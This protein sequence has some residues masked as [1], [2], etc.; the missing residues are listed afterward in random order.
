MSK[1]T[2]TRHR[3]TRAALELFVDQGIAA[4]TTRQITDRAKVAEGTLYRHFDSKEALAW[5]LFLDH[6]RELGRALRAAMHGPE[7]FA[8]RVRTV[9][10]CYCRLADADWLAFSYHLLYQHRE[11]PTV[12]TDPD[13]PVRVVRDLLEAGMAEG[14]IPARNPEL[15][16]GMALG[17]VLQTAMQRLYGT[18][19]CPLGQVADDLAEGVWRVIT[20]PACGPGRPEAQPTAPSGG[21]S[22]EDAAPD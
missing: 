3:L 15:L 22:R 9:V 11:Q 10:R 14:A 18:L 8:E 19:D 13:N 2:A 5:T 1:A 7:D 6:H 4:T 16:V 20:T 21:E 17:V 12:A